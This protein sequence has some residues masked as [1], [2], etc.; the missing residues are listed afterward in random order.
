MRKLSLILIVTPFL[1]FAQGIPGP[2]PGTRPT[3][4]IDQYE[5]ALVIAAVIMTLVVAFIATKRLKKA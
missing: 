2:G 1:S 4:P 5:L 3:A